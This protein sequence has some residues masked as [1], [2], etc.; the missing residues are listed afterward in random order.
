MCGNT[1]SG[2]VSRSSGVRCRGLCAGTGETFQPDLSNPALKNGDIMETLHI[3]SS[4]G[5]YGI[6]IAPGSWK[7]TGSLPG[8]KLLVC[9]SNVERIYGDWAREMLEPDE[10]FVF[11]AGESS[12]N[13]GNVISVCRQAARMHL[14][15]HSTFVAFGGGVTGDLAGFAAAIYLRGVDVVQ[16]PTTLLAMVDSG[17]GGKTAVDIPEGKNLVGAFHQPR[18]VIA[19]PYF[20]RTLPDRELRN[21]LAE[22]VKTAFLGD[23]SLFVELEKLG[24]DLLNRPLAEKLYEKIILRCC[25]VKGEV[26][27]D[28]E[29]EHGRRAVLNYGHTFGHALELLSGFELPH[30]EAVAIGMAVAARLAVKLERLDASVANRQENLL[31]ALGLPV[32]PPPGTDAESWLAAMAGDKKVRDGRIVLILPED[33]GRVCEESGVPT[34]VLAEF[35]REITA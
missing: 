18:R 33:V 25:R 10:V 3:N 5:G 34:G 16:I 31:R 13:I 24:S 22:V 19:D 27:A 4:N 17:I 9:D 28:D 35:L 15:R 23:A 32:A 6:F 21:G 2:C 20:L 26:V 12:K 1:S 11:P 29:Q 7:A 14:D 30:G 8:R